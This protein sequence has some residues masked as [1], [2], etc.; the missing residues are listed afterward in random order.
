MILLG[1]SPLVDVLTRAIGV[2]TLCRLEEV[3]L[4]GSRQVRDNSAGAMRVVN[5]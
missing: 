5:G 1:L 2:G 3:F 4:T